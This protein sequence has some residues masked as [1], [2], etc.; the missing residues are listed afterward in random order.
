VSQ[1][2][3]SWLSREGVLALA[4]YVPAGLLG[5][6]WVL[7]QRLDGP[8]RIAAFL[9]A[10]LALGTV[11]C[12]GMIYAS[13]KT[14]RAWHQPLVAP[15]Y[16]V[17]A[18]ATG[19]VLAALVLAAFGLAYRWHAMAGIAGLLAAS[20]MKSA[21]WKQ[22]DTEKRT[23]TVGAATGLGPLGR[24]RPLEPAH[25]QPNFV[26][27]EMGYR[28]ARKHA[29]KL[30]DHVLRLGFLVPAAALGLSLFL[31]SPLDL[32]ML[33]VAA[34]G[35]AF[36]VIVERWLFFAEAQHVVTLYYGAEAA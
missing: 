24:V 8:F 21:Y 33:V 22:I 1:W 5:L 23:H 18:L 34:L 15:V 36:G 14:I 25:A 16:L 11:W 4:T 27:R 30:R 7:L 12:T 31:G 20:W 10:V 19:A 2:R 26:M 17:L 35:A 3:S 6:G 9:A 13:L 28:V 32:L 29:E